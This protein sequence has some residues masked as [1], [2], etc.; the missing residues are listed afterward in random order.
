[1]SVQGVNRVLLVGH[2]ANDA[3]IESTPNK[4]NVAR[5]WVMANTRLRGKEELQTNKIA[6]EHW[7]EGV[8]PY[9]KQG[10]Q[11]SIEGKIR[12]WDEKQEDGSMRTRQCVTVDELVLIGKADSGN[13]NGEEVEKLQSRIGKLHEDYHSLKEQYETL[14]AAAERGTEHLAQLVVERD[15]LKAKLEAQAQPAPA[16]KKGSKK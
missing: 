6:C 7:G 11:V 9:L 3:R 4:K 12:S 5:F 8:F 15:A 13:G 16:A 14:K 2:L 10:K 1:M